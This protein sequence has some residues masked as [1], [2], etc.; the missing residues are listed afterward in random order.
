MKQTYFSSG[1][2]ARLCGTTKETLRHYNNIGLLK[3]AKVTENGYQYY[4]AFQFYD[5]YFIST[6]RGTGM[7]LKE[8]E[9]KLAETDERAFCDTLRHQLKKIQAE[10]KELIKKEKLLK[11]TIDK[12]DYL[13]EGDRVGSIELYEMEEEYYIATP[14]NGDADDDRVWMETL[15]NHLDYCHRG[16]LNEEYQL[17]YCWNMEDMQARNTGK[18]WSIMSQLAEPADDPR[19]KIKP[20]GTYACILFRE[21]DFSSGQMEIVKE[22][23][24]KRGLKICGDAYEADVSLFSPGMKAGY[25]TEISI[26]VEK[27]KSND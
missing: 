22:E 5:F 26:M 10:K 15:K 8:L 7:N 6:F 1:E 11:R 17:T 4:S 13:Y 21:Y 12:F 16:N 2:F 9:E 18:G 19:F 25:V 23:I 27:V 14:V 3:P 24:R 20:A